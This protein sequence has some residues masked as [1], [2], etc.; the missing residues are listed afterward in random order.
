MLTG[1]AALVVWE[2]DT[3]THPKSAPAPAAAAEVAPVLDA[4]RPASLAADTLAMAE[5]GQDARLGTAAEHKRIATYLARKYKVAA[6]ATQWIVSAAYLTG[7]DLGLDPYLL[8]AVM[9]IESRMNPYA[10]SG[11][12]AQGL[13]QVIP[14]YHLDKF[15]ELGG[16]DA[17][18]NPVAN[19]RVGAQILKE[20]FTKFGG[21]EAGLKAYS[22]ATDDDFG[23]AAKIMAE[24]DR[25]RAAAGL[26]KPAALPK[27]ARA[28]ALPRPADNDGE[29]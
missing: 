23:Y 29:A 8:L 14:K 24:R 16:A 3:F 20:Y 18:L 21:V 22:G 25:I 17:V 27:P 12:G 15:E 10:E 9:A 7:R 2:V 6:D 28:A 11:M 1:L 13:M 26:N 19:I 5:E 4:V